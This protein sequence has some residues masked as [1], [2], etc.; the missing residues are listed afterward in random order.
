MTFSEIEVKRLREENRELRQ[1]LTNLVTHY[2][3]YERFATQT[4]YNN[5]ANDVKAAEGFLVKE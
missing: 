5:I 3:L 1:L 4:D 2:R